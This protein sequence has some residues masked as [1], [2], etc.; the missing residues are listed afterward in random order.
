MD[1]MRLGVEKTEVLKNSEKIKRRTRLDKAYTETYILNWKRTRQKRRTRLDVHAKRVDMNKNVNNKTRVMTIRVSHDVA[2]YIESKEES[3]GKIV[4]K[5][6][7][8]YRD[9]ETLCIWGDIELSELSR[10]LDGMFRSGEISFSDGKIKW[11]S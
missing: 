5:A 11:N 6:V 9:L 10:Q 2:D 1:C 8:A 7:K 4:D 3:R